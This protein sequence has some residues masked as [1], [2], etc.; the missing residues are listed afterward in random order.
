MKMPSRSS[1]AFVL[2]APLFLLLSCQIARAQTC[3]VTW[4]KADNP[5]VISGTV[6]IPAGQT[7][8]AEPGVVVQ[9][10]SNGQLHL[11][12]Q[13]IATGAAN[14]PITFTGANV[15]PNRVE[16]LG[17]MEVRHAIIAVPLNV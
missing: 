2:L 17:T 8:C 7:V 10:T 3:D 5:R 1:R 4:R 13:L 12:G 15:S 14:D 16:V 11:F 9:F 6:T